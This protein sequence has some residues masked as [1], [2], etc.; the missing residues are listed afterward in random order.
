M[1][2]GPELALV[3]VRGLALARGL[4]PRI[5]LELALALVERMFF[6]HPY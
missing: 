6:E 5:E 3:P 2:R 1:R 4:E